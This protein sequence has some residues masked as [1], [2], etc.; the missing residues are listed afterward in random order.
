MIF[1]HLYVVTEHHKDLIKVTNVF[2]LWFLKLF[3]R[4]L[5]FLAVRCT[6]HAYFFGPKNYTKFAAA[7]PLLS[8][9]FVS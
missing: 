9:K 6:S 1:I 5:S 4:K 7:T 2:S 8:T 3:D